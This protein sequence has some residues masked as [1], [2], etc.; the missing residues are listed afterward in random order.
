MI[1]REAPHSSRTLE[2][3][4]NM[5]RT[6]GEEGEKAPRHEHL[7]RGAKVAEV[8][9]ADQVRGR[10]GDAVHRGEGLSGGRGAGREGSCYGGRR[11]LRASHAASLAQPWGH[12][13]RGT[14][15]R[16]IL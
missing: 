2:H 10:R 9:H 12:L 14:L 13:P 6:F 16:R 4:S 5:A 8:Q 1:D 7:H 11:G 15:N 3:H